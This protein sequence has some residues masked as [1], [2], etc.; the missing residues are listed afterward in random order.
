MNNIFT[1]A[2]H[3]LN[4]KL[5]F[6]RRPKNE[7]YTNTLL[8]QY[9]W[10]FQRRSKSMGVGWNTYYHAMNNVWVNAC[11]QTYLDEI[12]NLGFIINNPE[13]NEVDFTHVSYLENLFNNPMGVSNNDSYEIFTMLM[14]KSYLGLGDAFCEVVHDPEYTNVPIGLKH[15]PS[16][17]MKYNLE[18]DCWEFMNGTHQ[19][20]DDE[21]IHV[22]DPDIRGSVWGESKIDILASD[23]ALEILGRTHTSDILENNGLDPR[24]VLE[25]D[26]NLD[27]TKWNQEIARLSALSQTQQKTG[28]L[29]VRGGKYTRATTS[30]RDMEFMELMKDVRDRVLATYSVPPQ[31]VS[32]IETANLGS[33]SGDSQERQFKKTLSGKSKLFEGAFNKVLG[34][35]LFNEV[36]QYGD[37][38]LE[39]KE[40]RANIENTQINN[41]SVTINEVR[42]G[43]SMDPVDWGDVPLNYNNNTSMQSL[44]DIIN[45]EPIDKPDDI[46]PTSKTM[47]TTPNLKLDIVNKALMEHGLT[48]EG[49]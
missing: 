7:S 33:G 48:W 16:E 29:I 44:E 5:P 15:I 11:I 4:N 46:V 9:G 20:E 40:K 2:Y 45:Q 30:N 14:W 37:L 42:S 43:Y 38:D 32:I 34:R 6:L 21:L 17:Y 25:Y 24:G 41:G 36:F 31:K 22:K 35:S 39:D 12:I 19:F 18:N 3:T 49:Y 26:T 23:I 13:Q 27:D 8:N 10:T 47:L 28:T 1:K